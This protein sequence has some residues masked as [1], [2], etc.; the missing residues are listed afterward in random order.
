MALLS[1]VALSVMMIASAQAGGF[2]SRLGSTDATAQAWAGSA[3][4]GL[5]I[6]GIGINPAVVTS[7]D[8]VNVES[9]GAVVLPDARLGP[10]T[11]NTTT[12]VPGLTGLG[13][14]N[15]VNN[16]VRTGGSQTDNFATSVLTAGSYFNVQLSKDWYFGISV[17]APYGLGV[18]FANSSGFAADRT[19]SRITTVDVQPVLGYKVN[20]QLS[21]GFG[22]QFQWINLTFEQ[23]VSPLIQ[24]IGQVT[25][26]DVGIGFSAGLTY[27]PFKGTEFGIGYRSAVSHSAVGRQSFS[28]PIGIPGT[29]GSFPVTIDQTLPELVTASIR[30]TLNDQLAISVTG[31]WQNWR[32]ISRVN[33]GGSPTGT[34][35]PLNFRDGWF[36]ALGAEYKFDP[37]W[38]LRGGVAYD[39][40]PV[41]DTDRTLT[42]P[43][44]D[45]LI[46]SGGLQYRWSPQIT[47]SA[48]Y[49]AELF[50]K[51]P[52]N[53]SFGVTIP[54]VGVNAATVSYSTRTDIV[55]H[56]VSA[57]FTYKLDHPPAPIEPL[58]SK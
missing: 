45:R 34:S 2:A 29:P 18:T 31:E 52:I 7:L 39:F 54:G 38:T 57:G 53:R 49:T 13:V 36:V 44:S 27:T 47:L 15:L 14:V 6:G 28:I 35:L 19:R 17:T 43:D 20:D 9:G 1:G 5:G 11:F 42:V 8:G 41:T 3:A 26:S 22:V 23:R 30:Q 50:Q 58:L 46:F 37:K 12:A 10:T 48:A 4:P 32:R 16:A 24:G 21:V 40:S 33:V 55:A 25:G 56:L 51:A